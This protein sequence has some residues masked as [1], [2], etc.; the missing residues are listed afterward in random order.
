MLGRDAS[1]DCYNNNDNNNNKNQPG[2]R[3]KMINYDQS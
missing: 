3:E 2:L 1:Y